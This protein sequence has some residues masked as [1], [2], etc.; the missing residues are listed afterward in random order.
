MNYLIS[1]SEYITN[2]LFVLNNYNKNERNKNHVY[3]T[4]LEIEILKKLDFN[5]YGDLFNCYERNNDDIN[6]DLNDELIKNYLK[7]IAITKCNLQYLKDRPLLKFHEDILKIIYLPKKLS[8]ILDFNYYEKI[9]KYFLESVD[10]NGLLYDVEYRRNKKIKQKR[11]IKLL[12]SIESRD[13][14]NIIKYSD[15][16]ANIINGMYKYDYL[17]NEAINIATEKVK[18][19]YTVKD[20]DFIKYDLPDISIKIG[21]FMLGLDK[22]IPFEYN[23]II[24]SGGLLY[25]LITNRYDESVGDIDLFVVES[26]NEIKMSIIIKCIENIK[27]EQYEYEIKIEDS[28]ISIY[29]IGIPRIIQFIFV[30]ET[31]TEIISSFDF[32]H[33]MFYYDRKEL[34]GTELSIQQLKNKETKINDN[35]HS[36]RIIKYYNRGIK[37][38][39]FNEEKKYFLLN[40][41]NREKMINEHGKKEIYKKTNNLINL[42]KY[43]EHNVFGF[44]KKE[45]LLQGIKQYIEKTNN[46]NNFNSFRQYLTDFDIDYDDNEIYLDGS[47]YHFNA[48]SIYINCELIKKNDI[49]L[50]YMSVIYVK[51]KEKSIIN[52]ILKKTQAIKEL[53]KNNSKKKI[54]KKIFEPYNILDNLDYK[55]ELIICSRFYK[56]S[57]FSTGLT[58]YSSDIKDKIDYLKQNENFNCIFDFN[59]FEH[60]DYIEI[61]L[62]PVLIF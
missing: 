19:K 7:I 39:M 24:F 36:Y 26:N 14:F 58:N 34:Y 53:V 50:N 41:R 11:N 57:H 29:I 54:E 49:I 25:D 37:L 23:N 2:L 17:A 33:L 61:N 6:F 56:L 44:V 9:I 48:Y 51:I 18:P 59:I 20:Y 60:S 27:N 5:Y 38:D 10:E 1:E 16:E 31:K 43:D 30:Q 35:H 55:E 52:Y 4:S 13:K 62:A 32:T 47:I 42:H 46:I 40:C 12:T 45:E 28:V 8:E 22:V 15:H 3:N 21:K